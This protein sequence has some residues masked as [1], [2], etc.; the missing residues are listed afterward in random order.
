MSAIMQ[1][2]CY[3]SHQG[4]QSKDLVRKHQLE[5]VDTFAI[6]QTRVHVDRQSDF[7]LILL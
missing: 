5:S 4:M 1:G 7:A 6:S 2:F 3:L